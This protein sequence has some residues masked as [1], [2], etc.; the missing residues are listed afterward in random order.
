MAC[1]KHAVVVL[2]IV[3]SK[4][5]WRCGRDCMEETEQN[6]IKTKK[7]MKKTEIRSTESNIIPMCIYRP[8]QTNLMPVSSRRRLISYIP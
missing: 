5:R 6:K 1:G 8:I 7:R 3:A 4:T 2:V